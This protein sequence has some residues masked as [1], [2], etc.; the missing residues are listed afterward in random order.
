[1]AL[2]SGPRIGWI[3]LPAH[4]HREIETIIGDR[5][6]EA[7]SQIGGFSPGTAD[8]VVTSSGHRAFV[9]AANLALN[10]RTVELRRCP[11]DARAG[12]GLRADV[13]VLHFHPCASFGIRRRP[14]RIW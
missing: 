3:D 14:L 7:R 13:S 9:K 2:V 6:T 1:M 5:V 11:L 10:E 12:L 8:R 4:V